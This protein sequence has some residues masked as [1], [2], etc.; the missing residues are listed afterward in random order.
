MDT[1]PDITEIC[2]LVRREQRAVPFQQWTIEVKTADDIL[3]L[4]DGLKPENRPWLLSL[5]VPVLIKVASRLSRP[6]ENLGE[7]GDLAIP[8]QVEKRDA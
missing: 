6:V 2:R 8:T 4:L 7:M 3:T 1:K 5:S